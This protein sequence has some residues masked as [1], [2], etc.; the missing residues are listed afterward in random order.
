MSRPTLQ[1]C[2]DGKWV[3]CLPAEALRYS[4][5][6]EQVTDDKTGEEK[7]LQLMD[8]RLFEGRKNLENDF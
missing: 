8:L 3:P 6:A 2:I 5:L 1:M 4:Y 7:D